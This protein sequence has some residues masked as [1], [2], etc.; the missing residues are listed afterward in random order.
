MYIIIITKYTAILCVS[1]QVVCD[2]ESVTSFTRHSSNIHRSEYTPLFGCYTAG[3]TWN[4]C[5]LG[6]YSVYTIQPCT[7]LQ[8]HFIRTRMCVC[9]AVTCHQHFWT[10]DRGLLRAT[11]VNTGVER[12]PEWVSTE[13][14]PWGR[15]FSRR[16]CQDSN[17][18]PSDHKSGAL[19]TEPS[20]PP[21]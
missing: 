17:P 7:T 14:W 1:A 15:K 2:S 9:L 18:R 6:A 4:C 21:N 8:C 3:A 13:S 16:S 19:T 10:N 11:A 5:R 20:Q 12:I